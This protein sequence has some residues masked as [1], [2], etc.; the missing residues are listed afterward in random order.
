MPDSPNRCECGKPIGKLYKKCAECRQRDL[1]NPR[2]KMII[3][4]CRVCRRP[5]DMNKG[6]CE[7]CAWAERMKQRREARHA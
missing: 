7:Q 3:G 5:V 6:I 4:E 1:F 2:Y